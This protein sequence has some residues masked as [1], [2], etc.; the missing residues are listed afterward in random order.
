M[1]NQNIHVLF[2]DLGLPHDEGLEGFVYGELSKFLKGKTIIDLFRSCFEGTPKKPTSE[3]KREILLHREDIDA[4]VH[5]IQI[6][7][8]KATAAFEGMARLGDIPELK[9]FKDYLLEVA[10]EENYLPAFLLKARRAKTDCEK[11]YWLLKAACQDSGE[12]HYQLAKIYG[13]RGNLKQF[14]AH[15]EKAS[16]LGNA[17]ARYALIETYLNRSEQSDPE[18][19]DFVEAMEELGREHH[20]LKAL[21]KAAFYYGDAKCPC[22]DI[23]KAIELWKLSAA[24]HNPESCYYL[25]LWFRQQGEEAESKGDSALAKRHYQEAIKYGKI[26]Y[27]NGNKLCGKQLAWGHLNLEQYDEAFSL[28]SRFSDEGDGHATRTLGL[29]FSKGW[30]R[31]ENWE[32][33]LPYFEKAVAQGYT[34]AEYD[35]GLCYEV[36]EEYD[37]CGEHFVRALEEGYDY[38]ATHLAELLEAGKVFVKD[39]ALAAKL[40]LYEAAI[41]PEEKVRAFWGE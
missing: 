36:F 20:H 6:T 32:E 41:K 16:N 18:F 22:Y 23:E 27:T 1:L 13:K 26:G 19:K 12:A 38:T 15:L 29:F 3:L 11:E 8:T 34:H 4:T 37:R 14:V 25:S 35:I 28:F 10:V 9:S 21:T 39:P 2:H 17:D 33:A 31:E 7:H 40:R 24:P 30:G 5:V